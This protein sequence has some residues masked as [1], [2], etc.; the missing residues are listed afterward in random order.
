MIDDLDLAWEEEYGRQPRRRGAPPSRQLR[1]RRRKERKRRRRSFGALFVSMVLLAGLGLGVYW[2]VGKIQDYFGAPDYS[3]VGQTAV[4]VRVHSGDSAGDIA[5][6]LVK[7]GVI[8]STKAFID[9]ARN[10]PLSKNIQPGTYKLYEK[11]P[12]ATALAML[13]DPAHNR[14]VLKIVVPEGMITL[15]IFDRLSKASKI[16]L[17]EFV[18][19]GKDPIKLGVPEAWYTRDDGKKV[20]QS[21]EGFLFPATYDFDPSATAAEMLHEMVVKFLAETDAISF[22]ERVKA[23]RNLSPYEG[24]IAASIAQVEA[25]FPEDFGKV[26]RVLYNRAYGG[27]FPCSCLGLDSEVNYWLRLSGQ[28]AK[29]SEHLTAAQLHDPNDPYNTHDKPGLPIGPISNPGLDALQGAMLPPAGP[30]LYF[31]SIDTK[32]H[33]AYATTAAGHAA[34]IRTACR[35]GIPLC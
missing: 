6:T 5:E 26:A 34:N 18:D 28:E 7:N 11:M 32:G 19:A 30:W 12:A 15:D 21:I 25:V 9:A 2:G 20:A 27:N 31:I 29:A 17:K 4:N 13:L 10:N 16:P 23:E 33:M 14:V 35:N 22:T 8:K 24:L 1:Q 3:S